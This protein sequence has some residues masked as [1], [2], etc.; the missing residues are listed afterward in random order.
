MVGK[1]V[2]AVERPS[3]LE[4]E[5][6]DP[7]MTFESAS[8]E[9]AF[10]DLNLTVGSGEVVGLYGKI[11]SG[12]VEVAEVAFGIRKL[13]A[14]RLRI[15]G[16]DAPP[17]NPV[18]AIASGIGYLPADRQLDGAFMVLSVAENLCAP[19]WRRLSR[20]GGLINSRRQASAYNRWHDVLS[21]RSR[22]DPSQTIGTLSG[23]NQQ[24]VLL[25]RWLESSSR[26]LVL[27]EPTRGVDVGARAEIYR[28]I[29][30]L[31]ADGVGVL[32]VSSDY[33]EV[34][35]VSDRAVVMARGTVS[36]DLAGDAVTVERLSSA[37][38]E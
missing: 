3:V 7:L 4:R 10:A 33:E 18:R 19:S 9:A 16:E 15:G 32:V 30:G 26:L 38:G 23:G 2:G 25:G 24:K 12:T 34:V 27:V 13:S 36:A 6:G 11:G 1:E 21:I 35:Q 31:A 20:A 17:T 5:V 8:C 29:R 14:G 37:A 28:V 22:N